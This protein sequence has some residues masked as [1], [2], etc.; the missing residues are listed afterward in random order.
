MG[1]ALEQQTHAS[2]AR[3]YRCELIPLWIWPAVLASGALAVRLWC[4]TGLIASDD[5]VYAHYAHALATGHYALEANH[6]AIRF[7]LLLPMAGTYALLG[8]SE[9]TTAI[10]PLLASVSGVVLVFF[11]A[12]RQFGITAG[13]IAGLL[14]ASFPLTIRYASIL[15]PETIAVLYIL[16]AIWLYLRARDS[17]EVLVGV[18]AGVSLGVAYLT[19]ELSLFIVFAIVI[20]A[21]WQRR[22]RLLFAVAAGSFTIGLGEH[23]YYWLSA[24]DFWFRLHAMGEH[25]QRATAYL[26]RDLPGWRFFRALAHMMLIPSLNFGL[27]S[28]AG[29]ALA[30][31]SCFVFR[32][33][34]FALFVL[35]ALIPLLYLNFGTTSFKTYIAM[36]VGDRYLELI[37]PPLFILSG[38]L[39]ASVLNKKQGDIAVPAVVALLILSGVICSYVTRGSGWRTAHV[40]RLRSIAKAVENQGGGI[41]SFEGPSAWAWSDAIEVIDS[42]IKGSR[43]EPRFVLRPDSDGLPICVAAP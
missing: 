41:V 30:T 6:M 8:M 9:A 31:A 4:F 17:G 14:I 38:A 36:P 1:S 12:R 26:F 35:W 40:S 15:V 39:L 37:Y 23:L 10:F 5:V 43:S 29:L 25:N 42:S 34:E 28:L 21:A 13:V 18:F 7:G 33:R 3:Y 19:R 20:D 27:H 24:G 22:W 16:T 32:W 2:R 11:I